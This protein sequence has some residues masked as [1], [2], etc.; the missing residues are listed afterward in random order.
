[1][2]LF[3]GTDINAFEQRQRARFVNSLS[4]FK[5]ANLVG[6][7]DPLGATNLAIVSSVIHL[8]SNPALIG[9]IMRPHATSRHTL[10]N[11]QA[12]NQYTLN[13][14]HRSHYRQAHQTSARYAR[15]QSEFE[16]C[17]FS[18]EYIHGFQA[19]AVA[20]SPLQMGMELQELVPIKLNGTILVIGEIKWVHVQ[21]TALG[22]DGYIDIERLGTVAISGLD[23]YHL[24]E[25]LARLS[26]AKPDQA[27]TELAGPPQ[28]AAP[29]SLEHMLAEAMATS[30]TEPS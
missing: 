10:E 15:E 14:V 9:M 3:T 18:P 7:A 30:P 5:S 24:T 22:D 2:K 27:L 25:R 8:G 21:E 13:H 1:M 17:G 6:T 4:G 16:A 26:Y 12:L 23:G 19:P 29:S 20:E 28:N 11:I